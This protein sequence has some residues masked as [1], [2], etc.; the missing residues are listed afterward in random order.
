MTDD[1]LSLGE[2]QLEADDVTAAMGRTVPKP[3]LVRES[4]TKGG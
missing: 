1:E 3:A 4:P 2:L